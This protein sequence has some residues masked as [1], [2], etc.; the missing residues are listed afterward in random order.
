MEVLL[1]KTTKLYDCYYDINFKLPIKCFF[2][3]NK[4]Q[5]LEETKNSVPNISI[6]FKNSIR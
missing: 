1:L 5:S 3:L 6:S 2:F 4:F